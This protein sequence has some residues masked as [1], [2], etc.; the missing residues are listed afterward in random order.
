[1]I[2]QCV[3][4]RIFVVPYL[5]GNVLGLTSFVSSQAQQAM[6]VALSFSSNTAD[7]SSIKT[8]I[9]KLALNEEQEEEEL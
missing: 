4:S 5:L 1:M 3:L 7:A 8:A 9:E 6:E 2:P